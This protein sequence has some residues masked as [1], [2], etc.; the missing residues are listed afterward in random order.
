MG[1]WEVT[2]TWT[3]PAVVRLCTTA[4]SFHPVTFR[5]AAE[6]R[7]RFQFQRLNATEVER[8][9]PV[10]CFFYTLMICV[11]RDLLYGPCVL[12]V[13]MTKSSLDWQNLIQISPL[14]SYASDY[15][16]TLW[17]NQEA[18]YLERKG[19]KK[20]KKHSCSWICTMQVCKCL[21]DWYQCEVKMS[22][23]PRLKSL[24][25]IALILLS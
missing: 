17:P 12:A 10:F 19:L 20:I 6:T 22:I 18:Q 2:D 5:E 21:T 11:V 13:V 25:Q 7:L 4:G 14:C 9:C 15:G 8:V 1:F 16:A 23:N 3:G 24:K